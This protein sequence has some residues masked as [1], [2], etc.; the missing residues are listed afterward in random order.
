MQEKCT[1]LSNHKGGKDIGGSQG[2]V[3]RAGR[4]PK[5]S[6]AFIVWATKG[7][8]PYSRKNLVTGPLSVT[9]LTPKYYF[10]LESLT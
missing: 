6:E 9:S 3:W 8:M 5:R 10:H 4:N 7:S 1:Q 2:E